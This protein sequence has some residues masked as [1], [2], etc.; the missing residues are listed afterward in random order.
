MKGGRK[1]DSDYYNSPIEKIPSGEVFVKPYNGEPVTGPKLI[2][3]GPGSDPHKINS[4]IK[5]SVSDN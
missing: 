1:L 2:V 3:V 5:A 4:L